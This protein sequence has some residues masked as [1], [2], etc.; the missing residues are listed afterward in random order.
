[1]QNY[2][3]AQGAHVSQSSRAHTLCK[4]ADDIC[5]AEIPICYTWIWNQWCGPY[6]IWKHH[7]VFFHIVV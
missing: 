3:P 4:E 2:W 1:M 7:F 5:C 6:K